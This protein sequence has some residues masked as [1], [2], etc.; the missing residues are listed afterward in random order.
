MLGKKVK[1][2]SAISDNEFTF[3]ISD[4]MSGFYIVKINNTIIRKLIK[5]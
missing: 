1:S 4:L 2:Y 5:Q 3:D